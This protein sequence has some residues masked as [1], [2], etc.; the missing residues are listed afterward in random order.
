[1]TNPLAG[2]ALALDVSGMLASLPGSAVVFVA[3]LALTLLAAV[4]ILV[5]RRMARRRHRARR[6]RR[7]R[8]GSPPD[9]SW[10]ERAPDDERSPPPRVNGVILPGEVAARDQTEASLREETRL[11][12]TLQHVG[13]LVTAELQTDRLVQ[14]V[15]D[16]ATLLTGAA[17][18]AFMYH[19]APSR[20][21]SLMLYALSGVSRERFEPYPLPRDTPVF[22]PTLRGEASVRS[23]DITRDP[24]YGGVPPFFGLPPGHPP[25][26]SYLAVPVVSR[27]G[28]PLGGLF[29]GHPEPGRFTARHEREVAGIAAWAAVAMDNARLYEQERALRAEAQA[30]NQAKSEFLATMSHELRTPL[31]AI[32]GYAELLAM[33]VRGPVTR[34]QLEDLK[35]IQRSQ[36]HLLS[37]INDVLNFAK[38]E[39]GHVS[40]DVRDVALRELLSELEVLVSPQMRARSLRYTCEVC[41]ADVVVRADAEKVQ[42]ILLNL[43]SNAIKFTPAGGEITVRPAIDG[44]TVAIHVRDT[45]RGVPADKMERIFEPFVQLDRDFAS[46]HEGTG[47]GL[48]ISRD[49]A[50]AMDGDLTVSS[51]PGEGAT[52]TLALPLASG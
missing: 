10:R 37:L 25:V 16:E 33:G 6:A 18:G 43:L 20:G 23:D 39:A 7:A 40:L 45:G 14:L 12:E 21:E 19:V 2:A 1:M 47:L 11:Y 29:F 35:R 52:F 50:R 17:M 46:A 9:A 15:T 38:V 4:V 31:N 8:R 30:A 5:V 28:V 36:R 44:G 26:R 3:I 51:P 34:E 48:A 41:D 49:L 32:A 42:Q 27:T 22:G 24:R 13:S